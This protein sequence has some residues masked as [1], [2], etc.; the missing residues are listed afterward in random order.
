[1]QVFAIPP[2]GWYT[3]SLVASAVTATLTGGIVVV[4]RPRRS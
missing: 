2:P 3:V 1:V 4:W